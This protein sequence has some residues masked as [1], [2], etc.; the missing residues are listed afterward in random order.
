MPRPEIETLESVIVYKNRWMTVWEDKVRRQDGTVGHYGVVDK[1][2]FAI[3]AAVDGDHLYLVE[4]YR[5][6]VKARCWE[7]PQGSWDSKNADPL[8]LARA[9]L[10]EET[11]LLAGNIQHIGKLHEACGYST[12]GFNLFLATQLVRAEKD[13]DPQELGL[14]SKPFLITE[15]QDMI[16]Q[17]VITD[18]AT[19]ATFGLLRLRGLL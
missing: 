1:P 7:F 11:G 13:L 12:Q 15:V 2:D 18:A 3:I 16:C 14:I 17:G 19:V 6:P 8:T 4:Q 9:E 5:Y 10:R